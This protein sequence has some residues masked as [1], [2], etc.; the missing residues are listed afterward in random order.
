MTDLLHKRPE[1]AYAAFQR[2][3]NMAFEQDVKPP[4]PLHTFS[5]G[6]VEAAF[7]HFAAPDAAG[8]RVIEMD[9]DMAI[10]ANVT[11]K[12]RYTSP[13]DATYLI[14]GGLGGLGR[15]CARWMV[16]RGAR[17]LILLSRSGATS[18]AAKALVSELTSQGVTVCASAVDV[19]NLECLKQT[20][21]SLSDMMPPIRGCVQ[22][23][24]VLRD[25]TFPNMTYSDWSVCTNSKATASW[26]LHTVLP[27]GQANYAAGN[28]FKDA[29]ARHRISIGEKAVSIDLGLMVG[30]GILAE[31]E[32]LSAGLRRLGY[33]MDI[34]QGEFLGLLDYCCDPELPVLPPDQ[35]QVLVGLDTP[36]AAFAKGID[37]H[38]SI[39]RPMF[40]HLFR[41][42]S[43]LTTNTTMHEKGEEKDRASILRH[44]ETDE[45]VEK[46]VHTYGI[47]SLVAIDLKN[48]FAR[49]IGTEVQA[50]TLLGNA[51][52]GQVAREAV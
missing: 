19:S 23:T 37:L 9:A 48:W 22:A 24:V 2:A 18:D 43:S 29:L 41:M 51:P 49:E 34:S 7:H 21:T 8:K 40:R 45:Q 28:T 17:N 27:S 39:R 33:L 5:A 15:N 13:P 47:D 4:Q 52:L 32:H 3:A 44:A 16:S 31:N 10:M 36:A 20:L 50:L 12:P 1:V 46:P 30:Q 26:N 42:G 11:T 35:A 14:A 38:H 6:D 25:N